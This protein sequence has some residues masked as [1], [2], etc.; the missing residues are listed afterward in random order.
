MR[1]FTKGLFFE[2][3]DYGIKITSL[4]PGMTNTSLTGKLKGVSDDTSRLMTTEA[5][6]NALK[7]ALLTPANVCPLE[8]VVVNQKTAWVSPTIAYTQ[9]HPKS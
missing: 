3:R 1:A 8:I 5:I 9:K 4:I 6:E 2:M 7:F